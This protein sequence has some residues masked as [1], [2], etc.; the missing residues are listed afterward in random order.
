M[1][2]CKLFIPLLGLGRDAFAA[3]KTK[4]KVVPGLT[5]WKVSADGKEIEFTLRKGIKFHSGTDHQGY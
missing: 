5:S 4:T 3:D 1:W 2:L